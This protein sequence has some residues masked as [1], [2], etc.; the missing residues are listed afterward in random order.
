MAWQEHHLRHEAWRHE[1][2]AANL[3]NRAAWQASQGHFGRAAVLEARAVGQEMRADM[4]RSRANMIHATHSGYGYGG[5]H[6]H[7]GPGFMPP[8]PSV[9]V[10]VSFLKP[11]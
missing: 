6:Y 5:P 4:D 2:R 3:E 1:N 8:P 11:I 9:E 7:G 10:V